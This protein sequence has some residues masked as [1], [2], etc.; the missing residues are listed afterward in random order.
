MVD[1]GASGKAVDAS[2]LFALADAV[3]AAIAYFESAGLTCV[4]ANREYAQSN[5]WRA[6]EVVGKTVR[7]IIGEAAWI[8]IEDHVRRVLGGETV[9]YTRELKAGEGG[10]RIIEVHLVPRRDVEGAVVGAFVLITDITRHHAAEQAVRQA[11][12]DI[13]HL[14]R[15]DALT[16]LPNRA[17]LNERVADMLS[18]AKRHGE[19]AAILFVDLDNFKS[20]NDSLGHHAGDEVL[21][22]V[23]LRLRETLRDIDMVA[24][25]GGD[26]FL[27]ALADVGA[28]GDATRVANK[29]LA[30]VSAP[31][32]VDGQSVYVTTSI[33]ISLYPRDGE[34]P[35][36]LIRAADAA[37]YAAKQ[38][39]RNNFHFYSPSL[40]PA[41]NLSAARQATL[42]EAALRD[43]F[44]LLYQPQV[45]LATRGL[46]GVEAL[47]R[48]KRADGSLVG[49][50]EF[51]ELAEARGMIV[52]IGRRALADAC[53]QH[54]AWREAGY[55]VP[56]LAVNV[57]A[58]QFRRD[59]L[60]GEIAHTLTESG[61]AGADLELELTESSL[62]DAAAAG[63]KLAALRALGVR[64][65][66]DDFGT[67][68]SSLSYLHRYPIDKLKIDRSFLHQ[69]GGDMA[70]AIAVI[71]LA[72]AL[73]LKVL[74][75]G[76]EAEAQAR[77]LM[78]QGCDEAQ[79]YLFGAPVDAQEFAARHLVRAPGR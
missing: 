2:L 45:D 34:A 50:A 11:H 42:R 30:S 76:V 19:S 49:P 66:I 58:L 69:E 68:Y 72:K 65:A 43:E 8:A 67:G 31:L 23:A 57:S 56:T 37:M 74:A 77:F 70:I 3:P 27:V 21:K 24:R 41:S 16:G 15:H 47:L 62:M 36:A 14:A 4:F 9:R 71:R 22:E 73:N 6:S 20:I 64:I 13:E 78:E 79:G 10:A 54:R 18:L 59:A 61:T 32:A 17:F 51:L 12:A 46:T 44:V 5:G 25:V 29:L 55:A 33:G 35:D 75:E 38:S 7:E 53:R 40:S 63:E 28:P 26:E 60:I 52:A 1:S 39:G 48:W